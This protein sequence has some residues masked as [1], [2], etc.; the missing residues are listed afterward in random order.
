MEYLL[1]VCWD[2]PIAEAVAQILS[3]MPE[4]VEQRTGQVPGG[5]DRAFGVYRSDSFEV[6]QEL[7]RA[8][9]D[10]GAEVRVTRVIEPILPR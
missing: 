3:R 4:G 1:E 5:Q 6:V 8:I 9:S 2:D 7:A 10:L